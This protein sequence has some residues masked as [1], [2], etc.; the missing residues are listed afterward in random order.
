MTRQGLE[1]ARE[2]ERD[3]PE[4]ADTPFFSLFLPKSSSGGGGDCSKRKRKK[5]NVREVSKF[6]E[7]LARCDDYVNSNYYT[8]TT[9]I[10]RGAYGRICDT[11][12][13]HNVSIE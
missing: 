2:R 5:E 10:G 4:Y 8:T 6:D 7:L 12:I 1:R 9:T 11:H 13:E 3:G